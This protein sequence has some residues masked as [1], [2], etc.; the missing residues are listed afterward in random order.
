[1]INQVK[2]INCTVCACV[3]ARG[4]PPISKLADYYNM[5]T[6]LGREIGRCHSIQSSQTSV[7][8]ADR[9]ARISQQLRTIKNSSSV[10]ASRGAE[11]HPV[12]RL[13]DVAETAHIPDDR[14][15][16]SDTGWYS[17]NRVRAFEVTPPIIPQ[18]P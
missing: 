5:H 16:G 11:H 12:A 2:K 3:F 18:T 17:K 7:G 4:F 8:S 13:G 9:A 14:A 15:F 1:M 6:D 10:V